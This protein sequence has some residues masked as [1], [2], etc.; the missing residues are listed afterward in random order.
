MVA[1]QISDQLTNQLN[2]RGLVVESV[3]LRDIQLPQT[4]KA[5]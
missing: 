5:H 2:Q 3:L 4:L 1:K